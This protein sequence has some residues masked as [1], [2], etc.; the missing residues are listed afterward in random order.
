MSQINT[1]RNFS[2][3]KTVHIKTTKPKA[4]E[5]L[6]DFN[7]VYTWAPGVEESFGLTIK[8]A[9]V[10]AGRHCKLDGFGEIDEYVVEWNEGTGFVYDVTPLGPL[11]NALSRWE[12][13]DN[14]AT[15]TLKVEL[16]YDIRFGLLGKLMHKLIMRKKLEESLPDTLNALKTRIETGELYRPYKEKLANA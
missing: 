9:Q 14:G 2:I 4:W 11:T 10:G 15:T 16:N 1:K 8:Q 5:V 12:L 13:L 3:N 6:K 7:N